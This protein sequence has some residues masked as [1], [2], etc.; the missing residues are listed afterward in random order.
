[1]NLQSVTGQVTFD[2]IIMDQNLGAERQ[3]KRPANA[4]R[5]FVSVFAF[6]IP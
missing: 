4:E 1:M 3:Q 2:C 6:P 5:A